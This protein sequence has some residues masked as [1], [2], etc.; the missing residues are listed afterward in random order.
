MNRIYEI[1][2]SC[3]VMIVFD[4]IFL[5]SIKDISS[6]QI[7]SIQNSPI[8]FKIVS[9]IICYIFM[10]FAVNYFII[11]Q[12]KSILDAFLLGLI[13]YGIYEST[14]Y[15]IFD[16]WTMKLAIIDTIWGGVLFAATT[17]F[18]YYIKKL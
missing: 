3:I 13:I 4:S 12:N 2:I 17:Q 10:V 16:K 5:Y 7:L 1:I 9:A 18:I 6:K 11:N 14:N 15:T 8:K